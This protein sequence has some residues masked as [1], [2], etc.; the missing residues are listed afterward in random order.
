MHF[1]AAAASTPSGAP[2][3]P[4]Y[5]SMPV[6]AASA[7]W[8]TPATS[9]SVIS[10]IAAPVARTSAINASWRGRSR[11]HTV[12]SDA[13]QPLAFASAATR[14]DGLMLSVTVSTA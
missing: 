5:M 6:I 3:E 2:P 14:S 4:I 7:Q 1:N 9:P 11:I 12:M 8:I 13:A 10:R